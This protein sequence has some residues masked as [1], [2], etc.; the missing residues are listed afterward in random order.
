MPVRTRR[1]RYS[2]F[3]IKKNGDSHD[4]GDDFWWLR[5]PNNRDSYIVRGVCD[6]GRVIGNYVYLTYG[7]VLPALQIRL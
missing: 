1:I 3:L 5:S 4:S 7:G 2:C 6:D